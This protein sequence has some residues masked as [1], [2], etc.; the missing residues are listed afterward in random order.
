M[1]FYG[2][3]ISSSLLSFASAASEL[4]FNDVWGKYFDHS[5]EM[6]SLRK[7]KEANELSSERGKLHWAPKI[8][9]MSQ[10][11]STNDPGQVFINYL[12]QR[13]VTQQ[14]FNPSSLNFPKR[15][16]FLN[17]ILGVDLPLYEGGMK[18]NQSSMFNSL[19][20]ASELELKA[21]RTDEFTELSR[22]YGSLLIHDNNSEAL[23]KL[24]EDLRKI[25][26]SYQVGSSSNPVGY[27]GLLGLKGVSNR[28]E[29]LLT[30]FNL[31]FENSK[32]T[33][34][35]RSELK[36]P[37]RPVS[38]KNIQTFIDQHLNEDNTQTLSSM[39]L[40]HELKASTL[41][42]VAKMESARYLPKVGLFAQNNLY[43]GDRD[44]EN[45][46]SYGVYLM[47]EIFNSDSYNKSSEA[48]AKAASAKAKILSSKREESIVRSHLKSSQLTLE[49]NLELLF[50]SNN[51]L[52]EQSKN[53]MKLFKSGL[54]NALQ[55]AEVI[56]RRVDVI[57]QKN[58]AELQ[59][60]DVRSRLHQ[61]SH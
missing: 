28:I 42:F 51:L 17:G 38:V 2:L 40:A 52:N 31:K 39:L 32:Q 55:L 60:L 56:N 10:W 29:G 20:K 53:S 61:L 13:A 5:K 49:K 15:K 41:D 1:K 9:L 25:I 23:K 26:S 50:D 19:V 11:S 4:S 3:I 24:Q 21:K 36:D 34:S 47:W 27:S 46:Q 14:D 18:T 30:T 54:L 22:Q 48:K 57:E 8:S 35:E 37:W 59:Y 44:L 6:E 16:E 12:G 58:N 45:S 7:E 43:S 33:I